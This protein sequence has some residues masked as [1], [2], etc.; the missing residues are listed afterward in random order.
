MSEPSQ[1]PGLKEIN[2][3]K[4]KLN[5]GEVPAIYHMVATSAGDLD[6]I[7]THGFE[8]G[9]KNLLNKENWNLPKLGGHKDE[10]GVITVQY[11]PKISLRHVHSEMGYELHCYP[12]VNGERVNRNMI[13]YAHC[14]FKQWIPETMRRLFRVNTLS[15]FI[16]YIVQ[17]GDEADLALI[18][19]IYFRVEELIKLLAES[20]DVIDVRGYT[21]AEFYQ[22]AYKRKDELDGNIEIAQLNN[23]TE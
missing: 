3:H 19:H 1:M 6:G 16:M 17:N 21:I 14:P 13:D 22:E 5:W 18:K 12:N 11:K 15:N 4:K 2:S 7:L 9:Y 23:E 8:S 20:F 10:N